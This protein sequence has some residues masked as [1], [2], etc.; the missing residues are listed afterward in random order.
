MSK[1]ELFLLKL[2]FPPGI[3]KARE[4]SP[5]EIGIGIGG[6]VRLSRSR[7]QK[8]ED[9]RSKVGQG[10]KVGHGSKGGQGLQIGQ[11]PEVGQGPKVGQGTEVR[12][13]PEVGQ[14]SKVRNGPKVVRIKHSLQNTT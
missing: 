8:D 10:L 4:L 11:G 5:A 2:E 3:A 13:G 1:V 12:Q 6:H 14:G 9:L 7:N